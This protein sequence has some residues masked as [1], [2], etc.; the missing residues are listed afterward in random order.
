MLPKKNLDKYFSAVFNI[1]WVKEN[2]PQYPEVIKPFPVKL[3]PP[4]S[5]GKRRRKIY[6]DWY[7]QYRN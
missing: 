7:L 4:F 2:R 1:H 5:G 3:L 6:K